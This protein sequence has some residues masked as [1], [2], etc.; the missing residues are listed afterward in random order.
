MKIRPVDVLINLDVDHV[1]SEL[2]DKSLLAAVLTAVRQAGEA[3]GWSV[4]DAAVIPVAYRFTDSNPFPATWPQRAA[5]LGVLLRAV[6][7][8]RAEVSR[9]SA[10]AFLSA[11]GTDGQRSQ[12]AKRASA[13]AQLAYD[14]AS[15]DLAVYKIL[16]EAAIREDMMT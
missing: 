13:G 1:A 12:H 11:S 8:A 5:H 16:I 4:A 6:G 10:D 2:P 3:V 14:E 15:A 9:L 7:E